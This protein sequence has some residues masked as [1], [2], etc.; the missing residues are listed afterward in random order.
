MKKLFFSKIKVH[1]WGGL[2]SQ[3][4]AWA[5]AEQLKI[6]FPSKEIHIVLHNSGI[7]RR[8]SDVDFLS[9][10]FTISKVN[11]FT[12]SVHSNQKSSIRYLKLKNF[13]K[14]VFNFTGLTIYFSH[15]DTL[16]KVKPWTFAL[17]SH[18]AHDIVPV[19]ILLSMIEQITSQKNLH[20]MNSTKLQSK[21]G[22]HYR[23]GDLLKLDNKT[24]ISPD[25]L[26]TFI[27]KNLTINSSK[28]VLVYSDDTK[29]AKN[30]L[31]AYLPQS[32]QYIDKDVWTTLVELTNLDYFIGTNSKISLWVT[33][34]RKAQNPNSYVALPRSISTELDKILFKT[35]KLESIEFY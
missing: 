34:F 35:C 24:Y 26:G 20:F 25:I 30:Y 31:G 32:T 27:T 21:L 22:I 13:A 2:G 19:S 33:L 1:C 9:N 15:L 4:F 8:E 12:K 23:L 10:K 28:K 14:Y 11:D 5:M 7:T 18:Y 16:T 29:S 6:R 17:R 3:L